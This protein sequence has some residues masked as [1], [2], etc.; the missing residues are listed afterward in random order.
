MTGY[1]NLAIVWA[2]ASRSSDNLHDYYVTEFLT[3]AAPELGKLTRGDL[4]EVDEELLTLI[5]KLP[6][7]PLRAEA[8]LARGVLLDLYFVADEDEDEFDN[9]DGIT[10]PGLLWDLVS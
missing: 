7:G 1:E 2:R 4:R 10:P 8:N 9:W 3:A 6:A 5:A